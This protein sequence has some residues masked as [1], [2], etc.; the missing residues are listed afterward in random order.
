MDLE[1]A[2]L[3]MHANALRSRYVITSLAAT[4]II[5][6]RK[7]APPLPDSGP[8]STVLSPAPI[9]PEPQE[10]DV[11][12]KLR[13]GEGV[14]SWALLGLTEQCGICKLYFTG[15]VL[16]RHIFVCPSSEV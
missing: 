4:R 14:P 15:G 8:S 6:K 11:I 13:R 16:R 5:P 2:T 7:P 1:S 9:C 12:G 3:A 10:L